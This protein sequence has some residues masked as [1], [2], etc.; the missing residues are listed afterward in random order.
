MSLGLLGTIF[1]CLLERMA[2]E[3]IISGKVSEKNGLGYLPDLTEMSHN[4]LLT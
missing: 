4:N 2:S 1:P 3:I